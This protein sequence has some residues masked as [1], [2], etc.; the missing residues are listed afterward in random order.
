MHSEN[1]PA[2]RGRD[3]L[4]SYRIDSLTLHCT[5][6]WWMMKY[7]P[8]LRIWTKVPSR[9]ENAG[10]TARLCDKAAG[11]REVC[12]VLNWFRYKPKVLSLTPKPKP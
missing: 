11:R 7:M 6:K 3:A 4:S 1:N 5:F 10:N 12:A 2:E 8:I 9:D